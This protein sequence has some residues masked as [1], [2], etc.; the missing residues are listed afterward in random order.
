MVNGILWVLR[1]GAPWRD[2]PSDTAIGT[3]SLCAL[4]AGA[5]SAC[6]TR[7]LKPWQVSGPPADEEHAINSTI[8]RA[9]QHAAGIKVGSA[10]SLARR[11]LDEIHLRTNAKGDPLSFHCNCSIYSGGG[12][13]RVPGS[14]QAPVKFPLLGDFF[15]IF[16]YKPV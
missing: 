6:G 5:R 7:H 16:L 14:R 11:L 15:Q 8:V 12:L 3:Q 9:H 10:R 13:P 4:H 2:M 1:T